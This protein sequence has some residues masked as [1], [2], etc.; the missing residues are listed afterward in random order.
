MTTRST[1]PRD[2]LS[3]TAAALFPS[4][5]LALVM[6]GVFQYMGDEMA[7]DKSQVTMWMVPLLWAAIASCVFAT[8]IPARAWIWLGIANSLGVIA[9]AL[10]RMT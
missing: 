7:L 1:R 9:L 8:R 4:A 5:T 2:W 6:S 10:L 3:L